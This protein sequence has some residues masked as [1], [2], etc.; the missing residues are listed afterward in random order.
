MAGRSIKPLPSNKYCTLLV[1]N[2]DGLASKEAQAQYEELW[3]DLLR[4]GTTISMRLDKNPWMAKLISVQAHTHVW[5]EEEVWLPESELVSSPRSANDGGKGYI[6]P[7]HSPIKVPGKSGRH[8]AVLDSPCSVLVDDLDDYDSPRPASADMGAPATV[9]GVGEW[10]KV[11]DP[12][13]LDEVL[14]R[15]SLQSL[16]RL[17]CVSKG[18]QEVAHAKILGGGSLEHAKGTPTHLLEAFEHLGATYEPSLMQLPLRVADMPRIQK[19]DKYSIY[20]PLV[21]SLYA[22]L[23]REFPGSMSYQPVV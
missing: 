4:V 15:M 11:L 10:H 1:T 23:A 13:T 19:W 14:S 7:K 17:R 9:D 18:F 12:H 8:G 22:T 20:A 16:A 2:P 21:S 6:T 3:D 5:D